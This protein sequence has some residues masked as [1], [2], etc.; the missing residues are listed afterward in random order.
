VCWS[1]ARLPGGAS[2]GD[3]LHD[4]R[5]VLACVKS[6]D[7]ESTPPP[8][9]LERVDADPAA[10]RPRYG[11]RLLDAT[12]TAGGAGG[13]DEPADAVALTDNQRLVLDAL[14]DAPGHLAT[15]PEL[16]AATG[17]ETNRVKECALALIRRGY[18]RVAGEGPAPKGGGR[19]P[20]RYL[21]TPLALDSPGQLGERP[22]L[23]LVPTA[24]PRG[25]PP[26]PSE[27][28]RGEGAA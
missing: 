23:R 22:A 2:W 27:G 14:R 6:R 19:R 4:P 1:L 17:L 15:T 11:Y 24:P 13:W 9:R 7:A 25:R 3:P 8:I 26:A 28:A 21:C 12:G 5:R 20:T 16:A 10:L 18:A